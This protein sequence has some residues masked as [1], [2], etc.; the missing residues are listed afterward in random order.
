M[1]R[2]FL[3]FAFSNVSTVSPKLEAVM[4]HVKMSAACDKLF[5]VSK[6]GSECYRQVIL[7]SLVYTNL[8]THRWER[9]GWACQVCCSPKRGSSFAVRCHRGSSWRLWWHHFCLARKSI[10][11]GKEEGVLCDW[12]LGRNWNNCP[13]LLMQM[14]EIRAERLP[15]PCSS[16]SLQDKSLQENGVILVMISQS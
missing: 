1:G 10:R 15:A 14:E 3:L 16:P 9:F 12:K 13:L 11:M 2:C 8:D 6:K 4:H 7:T 5:Q